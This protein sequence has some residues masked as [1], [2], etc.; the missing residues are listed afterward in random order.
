MEDSLLEVVEGEV[1]IMKSAYNEE[2]FD[3]RQE[4][5]WKVSRPPEVKITLGPN[6]SQG[7]T[8]HSHIK[9]VLRIKTSEKYPHEPPIVV[10]E[11]YNGLSDREADELVQQLETKASEFAQKGT[12]VM[13]ELCQHTQ[14]YL[15]EHARPYNDCIY[16]EMV[17]EQESRR[18]ASEEA[19]R[20]MQRQQEIEEEQHRAV[21][22]EEIARV[23]E[24]LK[25]EE[26]QR[27]EQRFRPFCLSDNKSHGS[28]GSDSSTHRRI[29]SRSLS[30]GSSEHGSGELSKKSAEVHF[31]RAGKQ[32]RVAV[33]MG[34]LSERKIQGC[35]VLEAQDKVSSEK[36]VI[37]IWQIRLQR[38]GRRGNHVKVGQESQIEE[39]IGKFSGLEKEMSSL[40]RLS[41]NNLVH[42]MGMKVSNHPNE[43]IS[44]SVLQEYVQGMPIKY[45]MELNIP[46]HLPLIKHITEGTLHALNYLHQNN[47]VHRDLRDSCIFLNAHSRQVKIA[48]YGVER[49]IVEVVLEFIDMEVPS[50]YP[51]SPGR[52]GKKNDVYRLGLIVLS[53][54]LGQRVQQIVPTLPPALSPELRDFIQ[55]CLELSEQQRWTAECLLK[56][57]FI[58]SSPDEREKSPEKEQRNDTSTGTTDSQ[59][60]D[61]E[62]CSAAG[63]ELTSEVSLHLPS[64]LKGNSRVD[65][66]YDFLKCLGRGGFGYVFKVHNKVD[67]Q[68][69]AL[70][71]I[72]LDQHVEMD[73]N[74]IN[75]EVKLLSS[76]NHEN[77]VRYYTSWIDELT[78]EV[79]ESTSVE[80]DTTESTASLGVE[81]TNSSKVCPSFSESSANSKKDEHEQSGQQDETDWSIIFNTNSNHPGFAT[82]ADFDEESDDDD[83]DDDHWLMGSLRPLMKEED[84]DSDN[85]EFMYSKQLEDETDNALDNNV[86][87]QSMTPSAT[88]K[89]LQFLYIQ[90]QLCENNTLR[91]AINNG[92]HIDSDRTWRLF[93]EMVNGLDYIHAQGLIHRD[94][95]PGNVFID[96]ADHVKIGDFGLA[97]AAVKAKTTGGMMSKVDVEESSALTGQVG[98]T[99][100]IA[101]EVTNAKGKVS[102]TSKVDIYSLG[103]IFFEMIYPPLTTGMERVKVLSDI[104]RPEIRLPDDLPER[105]YTSCAELISWLLQHDPHLRPSTK[106]ILKSPLLPPLTAEEKKFVETLEERLKNVRS[107][108][109]QEI[110][111]LLFKPS[112]RPELEATFEVNREDTSNYW[113]Y[114]KRDYLQSLF[115]AIFKVH[116]G[117]WIPTSFYIPKGSFY[118]DKDNLVSLMAQKGELISAQFELRYPFARFIA[119]SKIKFMRR[120]CIDRV[121]RACKV[122]GIHPKEFYECAFDIVSSK[123]EL[124]ESLAR[125]MLVAHDIIQQIVLRSSE[126]VYIRVGHMDLVHVILSYC[127]IDEEL[128]PKIISLLKEWNAKRMNIELFIDYLYD[129]EVEKSSA[130]SLKGFLYIEGPLEEIIS[131]LQSKGLSSR[132]KIL[133]STVKQVLAD[134]LEINEASHIIGVKF[135]IRLQPLMVADANLYSGFMCQFLMDVPR[136]GR[137]IRDLLAQGGS[138]EHLILQHRKKLVS[139]KKN[140]E[141]PTAVGIS[142]FLDK[143][144]SCID[145]VT[146]L[147]ATGRG[148]ISQ[149]VAGL[150]CGSGVI[151]VLVCGI[152]L[153]QLRERVDIVSKLRAA[154]ITA[155]H[156]HCS[157]LKEA[158]AV[159]EDLHVS[160]SV[161]LTSS[162]KADIRMCCDP[163]GRTLERKVALEK[164][165]E[166]ILKNL[167]VGDTGSSCTFS[168]SDSKATGVNNQ[169]EYQLNIQYITKKQSKSKDAPKLD[170]QINKDVQM[171]LNSRWPNLLP[172]TVVDV[173][174]VELDKKALLALGALDLDTTVKSFNESVNDV[175]ASFTEQKEY[176]DEICKLLHRKIFPRKKLDRC[177]LILYSISSN[178][179]KRII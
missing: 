8:L 132:R 159:L 141:Q 9:V 164:V 91:Q 118:N 171:A 3:L 156:C 30:D 58:C 177:P 108:N 16:D 63:V 158:E 75:R 57:S 169:E 47:V 92:L 64:N 103:V 106:D 131:S 161:M 175:K 44:V 41:H 33:L 125:I 50:A 155:D 28:D 51:L 101:P 78:Q 142:L 14:N 29:K 100:Y 105:K 10:V 79:E 53:L 176:I 99:F 95:K 56:H 97:R 98:T 43:G 61:D 151:N 114:W 24:E 122:S 152:G 18:K 168:R 148:D 1:A 19:K 69:Y 174:P 31:P 22:Q 137:I 54:F 32:E 2:F 112:A 126:F 166:F 23:K 119:R 117:I 49:R 82:S 68:S 20:E 88:Q 4:D 37:Y 21:M 139:T 70:K 138:Y 104:R 146:K 36:C 115:V 133:A 62:E 111:N 124:P 134:L 83:D 90:M 60:E 107:S 39:L 5:P 17:A 65:K 110:L 7:G 147:M 73:R 109:Y 66:E 102:Y 26:L 127:G 89:K 81:I 123:R 67:G 135:D 38:T 93:R 143:F 25:A 12:V 34:C 145:D 94:L 45:F 170:Q 59:T 150:G 113:D 48:D 13:L 11:S 52:G 121:Q 72:Q 80:E 71:R 35:R 74:K 6:R 157:D 120:Y 160:N 96:S 116:G 27:K 149:I 55:R 167:G 15:G 154:N 85:V 129:L 178:I 165:A 40:L 163:T 86:R 179:C 42:Y 84:E 162:D 130:E 140:G 77:V 128:H 136:K 153:K 172:N 87:A 144:Y 173:W 76:L 46:I